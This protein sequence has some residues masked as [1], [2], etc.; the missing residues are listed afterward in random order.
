MSRLTRHIDLHSNTPPIL[1]RFL[2]LT[3]SQTNS[4]LGPPLTQQQKT[5]N[6]NISTHASSTYFITPCIRERDVTYRASFDTFLTLGCFAKKEKEEKKRHLQNIT[7]STWHL[8]WQT[9]TL[10]IPI[11]ITFHPIALH[12]YLYPATIKVRQVK[13]SMWILFITNSHLYKSQLG[14]KK[15]VAHA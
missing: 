6:Q 9:I 11:Y 1:P 15:L 8:P 13:Y 14:F 10:S 5:T 2:L 7:F 3:P 12:L 4:R